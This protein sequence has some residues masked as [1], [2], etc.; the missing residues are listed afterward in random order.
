MKGE[1]EML[2]AHVL[3]FKLLT[4]RTQLEQIVVM[5]MIAFIFVV[6]LYPG[7]LQ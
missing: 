2:L 6:N 4:C 3:L 5:L 1:V 7:T